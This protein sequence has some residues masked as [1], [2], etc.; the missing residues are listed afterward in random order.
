MVGDNA[1]AVSSDDPECLLKY[2]RFMRRT[3]RLDGAYRINEKLLSLPRFIA[4]SAPEIVA[5]RADVITNMGLIRRK[6]GL[7]RDSKGLLQ[8]AVQ[9]AR[10][11]GPLGR[12]ELGYALDNLGLTLLRIGDVAGSRA[13][14]EEAL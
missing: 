1:Q 9:T 10:S 14:Y 2:A 7:L 11:C 6:Q 4:S 3:G 5:Q 12:K 13:S 8:E